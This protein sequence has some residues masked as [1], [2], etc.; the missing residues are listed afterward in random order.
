MRRRKPSELASG[1]EL[2][3][4]LA[5]A[6]PV[7]ADG[8]SPVG[9]D[10]MVLG[11]MPGGGAPPMDPMAGGASEELMG[12]LPLGDAGLGTGLDT[13]ALSNHDLAA[14][15]GQ[16]IPLDAMG[17][18][19]DAAAEDDPAIDELMA[20]VEAGDPMAQQILDLAARRRFAGIG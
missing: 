11:G 2:G 1:L 20:A 12:A 16:E 8:P 6:M 9:E 17:G 7:G 13:D 19:E 5:G 10:P 18:L 3:A 15:G 4:P 14:L